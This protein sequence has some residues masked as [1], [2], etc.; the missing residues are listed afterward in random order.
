MIKTVFL[1]MDGVIT[2]FVGEVNKRMG[3]PKETIPSK[4]AWVEDFGYTLDQVN[5]WCTTEFW[6]NLEWMPD[7]HDIMRLLTKVFKSEQIYLL[8]TPMPNPESYT[9]KV[10]WVQSH[11]PE[12]SRRL[13]VTSAPKSLF[14][15][16]DALLIDDKTENVDDF[17]E[18]NGYGLLVPRPWNVDY[19]MAE[20]TTQI[21]KERLEEY[22]I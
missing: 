9:G 14:A 19:G 15:R 3:I 5:S 18:A 16:P 22:P 12:F 13:I 10:L 20:Y 8:T 11:L 7:G 2:D 6:A 4:W 21:V 17:I 1:D